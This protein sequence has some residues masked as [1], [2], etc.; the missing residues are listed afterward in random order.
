[1]EVA[2]IVTTACAR[3]NELSFCEYNEKQKT[4]KEAFH[5]RVCAQAR[6][7]STTVC[8]A[9]TKVSSFRLERIANKQATGFGMVVGISERGLV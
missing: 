1:M 5:H 7:L 8:K 9:E 4:R 6:N 2:R 3:G